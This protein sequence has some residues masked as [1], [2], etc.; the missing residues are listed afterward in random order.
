LSVLDRVYRAS[1][2][3]LQNV[4]ISTYGLVWRQRRFGGRFS[5]YVKQFVARETLPAVGWQHYQTAALRHL[6]VHSAES[7]PYYRELFSGLGLGARELGAFTIKDLTR[8]PLLEKDTV[9][10]QPVRLVSRS[11][12]RR[13][14]RVFNTSG[15]TGTPMEIRYTDDMHQRVSAA[16]EA[17]VRRWA[18]VDRRMSRAMIGGRLVV[19][20]GDAKP[21]FWRYNQFERQLYMSA[22]HISAANAPHYVAALN[23]YR[24]DY[25]VG[26]ASSHYFLARQILQQGL[27][28]HKPRVVLT[29]S[30]KL[31][32]EMRDT[33]ERTYSCPVFDAYSGVEA[34]CLA[35]ECE[36]HRLH[37]SPDV[38]IVELLDESGAPVAP[39]QQG[40]IAATGLLNFDQPLI[41]YRTGDLA[42]LS[43][44][45]CPCGRQM[46][47]IEELVGRIEDV[48]VGRDGRELVRFHGIFVGIPSIREGQVIQEDLTHFRLRLAVDPEF[49]ESERNVVRAR[50]EQ[51]LGAVQLEFEYVDHI[52]RTCN[53]KFQAVVSRMRNPREG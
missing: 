11:V 24:P 9:R 10:T 5:E 18:G 14:L 38:G 34:C 39:G 53:G 51:R 26:Y 23:R 25:L 30:E 13:Q 43:G 31:T 32:S 1:P 17:R 45:P 35:S 15:T 7:V 8:L 19:P 42:R 20:E 4:G 33:L 37:L 47:L 22:F 6:L 12:A 52:E 46:P 2:V 44:E 40:E 3:W 21:P 36:H 16:Y 27:A 41:R 49:G 50:F 28:V 48:V 29:S